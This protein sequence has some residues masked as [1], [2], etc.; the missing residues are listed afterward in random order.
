M[1]QAARL[2]LQST[3]GRGKP[4]PYTGRGVGVCIVRAWGTAC[5]A[6][7]RAMG[8]LVAKGG[9]RVD[10]DGAAGGDVAGE[11]GD[12]D[13]KQRDA[14]EGDRISWTDVVE[15]ACHQ[16]RDEQSTGETN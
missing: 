10:A 2:R 8:L 4:R 14:C 9:Q 1:R 16:A 12:A 6:L 15:Q 5:C 13:E 3:P 11:K 7:T